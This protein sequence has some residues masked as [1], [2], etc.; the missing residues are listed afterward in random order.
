MT[1]VWHCSLSE[2]SGNILVLTAL[3]MVCLLGF[4]GFA[5]D[6]GVIVLQRRTAQNAADCAAVEGAL[7]RPWASSDATTVT[8]AAQNSASTNGF[9]NGSNGVT[10]SVNNPPLYGS[11]SGDSNYVEVIVQK[12]V[13]TIFLQL[14][15]DNSM[16][17]M[18]RAVA[19]PGA[20]S[21]CVYTLG[22][23]GIGI[24]MTAAGSLNLQYC[25][26]YDNSTASNA[27]TDSASGNVTAQAIEIVGGYSKSGSGAVSPTPNTSAI[28]VG[29]PLAYLPAPNIPGGCSAALNISGSSPTHI[30]RGCYQGLSD[31]A[32]ALL[33]LD[34]GLYI[35]NGD[36]SLSGSG[37]VTG[38]GVTFYVTG[39]M[40]M[41][42]SG[43]LTISAPTSGTYN[44][45]VYFQSRTDS[46]AVSFTGSGGSTVSGI[47]YAPDATFTYSASGSASINADFVVKSIAYTGSGSI[48]NYNALNGKS[49]L[50]SI[51]LTE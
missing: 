7:E 35:I 46:N 9:T 50:Q 6:M 21:G 36:L 17:V 14:L 39:K 33:T 24:D 42:S 16:T 23:S 47:F 5:A 27:F 28:P 2:D 38:T 8:A 13:S 1:R 10:V 43:A 18:A 34:P 3:F 30:S 40:K 41:S 31:S 51:T 25:T 19:G 45:I 15:N 37:G 20:N 49:P 11:H 48:T 29:D 44:G 32:S 22:S 4:V 26:M 12:N